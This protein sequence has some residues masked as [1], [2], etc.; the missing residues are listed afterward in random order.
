M[1]R[2][3]ID[4]GAGEVDYTRYVTDGSISIQRSLNTPSTCTISLNNYD[5]SFVLPAQR[6]YMRIFSTLY[7]K[8]LYTGFL[9]NDPTYNFLAATPASSTPPQN[10]PS[11]TPPQ[12]F[13]YDLNFTSD[14]YLL[15]IKAIAFI[16]AFVNQTQG[17]ILTTIANTLAPGY[18]D[19]SFVASG[20]LVPYLLYDP[21]T[22][23]AEYAKQFGDASNYR[24]SV[25][26]KRIVFQPYG[27]DNLGISYDE[28]AGQGTFDP[29][30]LVTQSMTTPIVNDITVVGSQE[31]GNN[32]EDYF[33]GDGFTGSFPLR[34]QVFN[35]GG[36]QGAQGSSGSVLIADPWSE[37]AFNAQMW[38]VFD[39]T[40]AYTLIDNALNVITNLPLTYGESYITAFNGLELA[41]GIIM[42]HGEFVFNA[43]STGIVGGVFD[44]TTLNPATCETGFLIN[45]TPTVVVTASGASGISIQPYRLG[46]VPFQGFN[47]ITE[48]N[49]TY[50]L[51][52]IVSSPS[53]IR[54]TQIYTTIGGVVFGGEQL[55]VDVPANI[56]WQVQDTNI[57]TGVVQTSTFTVK[58][59]LIPS[60][61]I[62]ALLSNIQLNLS[63][64]ATTI[65]TPPQGTLN[66]CSKI[67]A[68]LLAP[69]YI[70]GNQQYTGGYVTP[71][72][73]NLPI[74][75]GD[76]GPEQQWPLGS[77][78]Q[79]QSAE[80]DLGT[81]VSSLSFYSND[82]PGVGTRIRLQTWE[83]QAAVS[84]II[85]PASILVEAAVVGD[86]GHRSTIITNM[87]PLPRS[88]EDCDAA[89]QAYITDRVGN[90]YQGTYTASYLFFKQDSNNLDFYPTC[91]RYLQV[92]SPARGINKQ[93]FL[94]SSVTTSVLEMKGEIM[95]HVISY[96]PDYHF[97]KVIANFIEQPAN[98]LLPQ[99]T[100]IQP[101][102]QILNQLGSTYLPNVSSSKLDTLLITGTNV[103]LTFNDPIPFVGAYYELRSADL[104]WG[105][106]GN[107]L[108]GKFTANGSV[109][110]PRAGF[111]Q[112]WYLRFVYFP[113]GSTTPAISRRSKV[114]RVYWPLVPAV[115]AYL[116]ADS[117]T[118]NCDFN[119]DIRN[120]EGI[121]L[122]DATGEF[123]YYDGIVGSEFDMM[124]NLDSL[125]G[126][127]SAGASVI[128]GPVGSFMKGMIPIGDTPVTQTLIPTT[129]GQ[130]APVAGQFT[131]TNPDGIF[132]TVGTQYA[133]ASVAGATSLASFAPLLCSGG[134]AY[135]IPPEATILKLDV[136]LDPQCSAGIPDESTITVQLALDGT[137]IGPPQTRAL[138]SQFGTAGQTLG[139]P[140]FEFGT[141]ASDVPGID[142]D[143][144]VTPDQLNSGRVGILVSTSIQPGPVI[145]GGRGIVI[146]YNLSMAVAYVAPPQRN[147]LVYFFNLMWE[148]SPAL[149]V[150]IPEP[151]APQITIGYRWGPSLQINVGT[152]QRTDINYTTMQL[153]T[154][155]ATLVQGTPITGT[156]NNA[157]Q[158]GLF[159]QAQTNGN[160]ASFQV[161]VP[162]TGD[163][164]A[165][166]QFV[167]HIGAGD[168]S[169]VLFIPQGNLIASD[170]LGAQGSVPPTVTNGNLGS[171]GVISYFSGEDGEG[172]YINMASSSF[173]VVYP[174][175]H[176]DSVPAT[177][178]IN[179][180]TVD[181]GVIPLALGNMYGFFPSIA[182]PLSSNP[183]MDFNGP[184]L[185]YTGTTAAL[186]EQFTDG[187][188]PLTNGPFVA[189][190]PA[191]AGQT[192]GG[193]GGGTGGGG[194][195]ATSDRCIELLSGRR[196]PLKSITPGM[197]VR[198]PSGK[199]AK[200]LRTELF[201]DEIVT[202]GFSSSLLTRCGLGHT[203]KVNGQWKSVEEI[204]EMF[205]H[206][207]IRIWTTL[208]DNDTISALFVNRDIA[209]ICRL[210]LDG[211]EHIYC[212][213][214]IWAHNTLIKNGS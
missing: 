160:P 196:I 71:S 29:R 121:E 122:R 86:D 109:T 194:N 166:V 212:V 202:L 69:I 147:F 111:E 197:I 53:P 178:S 62:Y 96:G 7:N 206:E 156:F 37:T 155:S 18:F 106:G 64:T 203:L 141:G 132:S 183:T 190:T 94:V 119:G 184:Y 124:L 211:D 41:G 188:V 68:G 185:S 90:F 92:N 82:L 54:Y 20:Q 145:G 44:D 38:N 14:E 22:S 47:I 158:Q 113:A 204:V 173:Q 60:F 139:T 103:T 77:S 164:Y 93:Q 130:V 187:K 210:H 170:Y 195:C 153:S 76:L 143:V 137:P 123:V 169:N 48:I 149:A 150:F 25:I 70:S 209:E 201:S 28:T 57:F 98:V 43:S 21:T 26:D 142:W 125:R 2:V 157:G 40:S 74:L 3:T 174:N 115:P 59:V 102:P 165:R 31:A 8:P 120:I 110:L 95:N 79:N 163:I 186:Q 42:Q 32:H 191:T 52:T 46:A 176:V 154:A 17:Q 27:D 200:V 126:S 198:T 162:V 117:S 107:Y 131:W 9:V 180:T 181:Q 39:P 168:W 55:S 116:Y 207:R 73:G 45:P 56:T 205:G 135:D 138:F 127:I 83:S 78:L 140:F 91:G 199:G 16:P 179:R 36:T 15:Q 136:F 167:D 49:H 189:T 101:L 58:D 97:E 88:S 100:V 65:Y 99:D 6:S 128:G 192:T 61:A 133:I 182:G 152:I 114:L 63:V 75:P 112:L 87:N 108:L 105:Q 51:S 159:Y 177:Y 171:G 11:P 146:A 148:Y 13:Q 5:T 50:V 30:L 1:L 66:V 35:A 12:L 84:R 19:T 118:I 151:P 34:H 80:I 85:D 67:G 24:Y 23:W 72:G 33:M 104:N 214:G 161:N 175:G 144:V 89:G 81:T 4:S 129:A 10:P 172:V 193:G 208:N 213:D 134:L